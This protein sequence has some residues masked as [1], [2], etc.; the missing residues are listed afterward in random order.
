M[1]IP[2]VAGRE[3][4][5]RGTHT[6]PPPGIINEKKGRFFFDKE[7]PVCRFVRWSADYAEPT[8]ICGVVKGFVRGTPRGV[9]QP[10]LLTVFSY[11]HREALNRGAQSRL[12]AMMVAV[13]TVDDPLKLAARIRQELREIDPNLPVLRINTIE[14]QLSDVLAQDRLTATLSGVFGA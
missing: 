10:E 4:T 7:K 1:G 12:R 2:L 6:T 9:A 5:E 11:R 8:E 3:F 14:E 13:R